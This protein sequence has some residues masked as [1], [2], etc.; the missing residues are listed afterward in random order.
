M[1]RKKLT[2]TVDEEA[3]KRARRYSTA[4]GTSISDL[5]SHFL[6]NL[7]ASEGSTPTVSRLRGILPADVNLSDYQEYLAKKHSK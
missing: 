4:R 3:I 6:G 2:L 7:G 1:S 5:V